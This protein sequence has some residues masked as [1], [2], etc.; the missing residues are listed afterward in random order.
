MKEFTYD[1]L[2]FYFSGAL[3]FVSALIPLSIAGIGIPLRFDLWV[4]PFIIS[5]IRRRSKDAI[6][7]IQKF[8]SKE[9]AAST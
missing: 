1:A 5:T 2:S 4:L 6:K 7:E 8:R 9:K 3:F